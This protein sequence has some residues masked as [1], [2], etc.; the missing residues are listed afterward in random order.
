MAVTRLLWPPGGSLHTPALRRP[1]A[2]VVPYARHGIVVDLLLKFSTLNLEQRI[3]L[4]EA[5]EFGNLN[6]SETIIRK[7][8]GKNRTE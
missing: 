3:V 8:E 4:N 7:R 5:F 1:T 6:C 2:W